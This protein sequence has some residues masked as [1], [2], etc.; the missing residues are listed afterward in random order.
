MVSLEL[1][2][3]RSFAMVGIAVAMHPISSPANMDVKERAASMLYVTVRLLFQYGQHIVYLLGNLPRI[4]SHTFRCL[5]R[6]A[7][8]GRLELQAPCQQP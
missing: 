7:Y 3:L 4:S 2:M 8:L 6:Q 1:P 5:A